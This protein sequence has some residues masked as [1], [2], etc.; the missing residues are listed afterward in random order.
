M[1]LTT[2]EKDFIVERYFR[3]YTMV[4]RVGQVSHTLHYVFRNINFKKLCI[5]M[6]LFIVIIKNVKDQAVF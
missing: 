2:A 4:V 3:S 5:V 6:L 1:M